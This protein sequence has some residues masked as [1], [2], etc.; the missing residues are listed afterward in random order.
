MRQA[1]II[2]YYFPPCGGAGVQRTLKFVKYLREFGWEPIVLTAQDA[3]YPAWDPSLENEIPAD[4]LVYRAPLFEPYALYRRFTGKKTGESTDMAAL[5]HGKNRHHLTE[6][7]SELI[8]S[9]F[10]VPDARIG[11]LY[12]AF[13]VGKQILTRH[14]IEVIFSSAPPYTTHLI[15]RKLARWSKKPW[16]A[17]FRD[18]WIGWLSAPQWRPLW[19]RIM[20]KRMER[21]VLHD[22]DK[23]LTV[24]NGVAEDLLSRHPELR[25]KR[26]KLLPNGYDAQDFI[27]VIPAARSTRFNITYT[28]SMYGPRNPEM[29]IQ[30]L[31]NM[32]PAQSQ[33]YL[34]RMVGRVDEAILSRI[35]SSGVAGCFEHIPY[36]T[37]AQSLAYLLAADAALLIIDDAPENRGIVTGKVYEYIGAG[38]PVLALAPEGDAADLIRTNRLGLVAA[39]RDMGAIQSALQQIAMEPFHRNS[40]MGQFE[41]RYL[42]GELAAVFNQ[43]VLPGPA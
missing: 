18:S 12:P 29:L 31:E 23:I 7:I 19:A 13:S 14:R 11:W 5:S 32:S 8:R 39:P 4:T 9:S 3:D 43:V 10:F 28:G 22:A 17:D 38:L 40:A 36:V 15:G 27:D 26:W 25:D 21:A 42:T 33:K 20:E 24:S 37:H 2:T 16:V 30:A 6:K 34:V 41:R 35:R 1:L